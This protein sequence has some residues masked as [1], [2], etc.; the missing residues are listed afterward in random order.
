[1]IDLQGTHPSVDALTAFSLGLLG[2]Q[3]SAA[4]ASHL[5]SCADCCRALESVREDGFVAQLRSAVQTE[6]VLGPTEN[7]NG[8]AHEMPTLLAGA[9][10]GTDTAELPAEL[11]RHARYRVLQVLG[12]GGMGTVYK[13][14]HQLMERPVALKVIRRDLTRDTGAVERFHREV[15]AAARLAH[16]NIVHAYDAEQA[17]DT[18]LLVMEFVEGKSLDRVIADEGTLPVARACDYLRQAAL[19]LQHAFERGMVHRDIKPQNLMRT[20]EGIIKILDFG[21]AR[22]ARESALAATPPPTP[23]RSG[24]GSQDALLPLS[25]SGRGPGGGVASGPG[26][27]VPAQPLTLTGSLM[28]TPDYMAPEQAANPHDADIRA[29]IYSLGCTLYFLLTGRVPFPDVN[30]LDKIMAHIERM[31]EPLTRCR[32]DVPGGLAVVVERMMSKDPAR[33]YQ[34]PS[35]VVQTLEPFTH[36]V[37]APAAQAQHEELPQPPRRGGRLRL[38][39]G[40]LGGAALLGGLVLLAQGDH[41][42]TADRLRQLYTLC[43]VLGGTLL[44]CQ[45]LLSLVGLGHHHDVDGG[46]AEHD[47][48]GHEH[49]G[50]EQADHESQGS[51]F[52][53][54]LTFRTVVAALLF[55]GLSGRA[56][57]AAGLELGTT[58]A[59]A[60]AAGAAALF[61]VAWM[62]K[63]LYRLRADGTVRIER[64]VGRSGTVYLTIPANKTGVG[65]VLLNVQNRTVEYQAVTPHQSLPAGSPVVVLAV[66]NNDTVEVTLATSRGQESGVRSQQSVP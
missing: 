24:E 64:A 35:E 12:A 52:V 58:L 33:R 42:T 26:G 3:E 38:V 31:P 59:V 21:L 45:F 37:E 50:G 20:P 10:A 60:L 65:K 19:G 54:V 36:P 39:L 4:L 6:T 63:A 41:E 5:E 23:P 44:A 22:F 2:E 14:E 9:P 1:M 32:T 62:M 17:G 28:G 18:H 40:G 7:D 56:A 27:G 46:A 25:A 11:A 15:K 13:A 47:V 49:H 57:G 43:A 53:G 34:T 51:W 55:F 61:G 16:P 29:D 30:G 48:G 66:V 8:R